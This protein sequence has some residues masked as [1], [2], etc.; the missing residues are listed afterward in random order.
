MPI[1][2]VIGGVVAT[3][4]A[5]GGLA[6]MLWAVSR[7]KGVEVSL[8]MLDTANDGLRKVVTDLQAE[9]SRDREHFQLQLHTQE[10]ECATKI[11]KLEGQIDTLTGNLADRIIRAVNA[12]VTQI[13]QHIDNKGTA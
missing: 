7:V 3:V 11:A 8:G 5:L 6:A 12:G 4:F 10:K 9:K 2:Q 1:L 13:E